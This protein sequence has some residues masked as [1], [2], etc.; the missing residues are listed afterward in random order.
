MSDNHMLPEAQNASSGETPDATTGWRKVLTARTL[1]IVITLA[2]L[3]AGLLLAG[4]LGV[5]GGLLPGIGLVVLVMLGH[6]F[7]HGGHGGSGGRG[8]HRSGRAPLA[9]SDDTSDSSESRRGHS[10]CH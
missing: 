2:A 4:K 1:A 8:A 3:V 10:G 6:S 5:G 7:M 9:G